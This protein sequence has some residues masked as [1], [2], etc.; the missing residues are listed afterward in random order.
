M[1]VGGVRYCEANDFETNTTTVLVATSGLH[2]V[3]QLRN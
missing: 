1:H 2:E 3:A